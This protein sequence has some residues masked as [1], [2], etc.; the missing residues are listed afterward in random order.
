M[1]EAMTRRNGTQNEAHA[2]PVG[3]RLPLERWCYL[4]PGL[5][6]RSV[7][8]FG[9]RAGSWA[10][11]VYVSPRLVLVVIIIAIAIAGVADKAPG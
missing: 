11:F 10:S 3:N 6:L 2:T 1:E 9:F 4:V 5:R 7:S 8:G